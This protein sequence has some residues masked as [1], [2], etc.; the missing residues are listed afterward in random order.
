M[1]AETLKCT[2][3]ILCVFVPRRQDVEI[4]FAL[5]FL[6]H[7]LRH[8]CTVLFVSDCVTFVCVS[9]T[10]STLVEKRKSIDIGFTGLALWFCF[11]FIRYLTYHT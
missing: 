8:L 4:C 9:L 5:L 3:T 1:G 7:F 2:V 6:L 11:F 10:L